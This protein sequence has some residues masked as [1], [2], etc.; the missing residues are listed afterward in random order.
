MS[1][2]TGPGVDNRIRVADSDLWLRVEEDRQAL[3]DEPLWGYGKTREVT[4]VAYRGS[5]ARQ[6]G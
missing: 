5:D 4:I 3:G 1:S 6:Q 2:R